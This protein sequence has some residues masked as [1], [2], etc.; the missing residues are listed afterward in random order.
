MTD[1]RL[2]RQTAERLIGSRAQLLKFQCLLGF[3]GYV[4][5][6]FEVVDQRQSATKFTSFGNIKTFGTRISGASGKA[7]EFEIVQTAVRPGGC[8]P[9]M[10][11]ALSTL[12]APVHYVGMLGN[13]EVHPVFSEFAKRT[14]TYP[15]AEPGLV[16]TFDFPDGKVKLSQISGVHDVSWENI[17]KRLGEEPFRK[18]WNSAHFIGMVNWT[19][20]PHLS[21]IWK[22][23]LSDFTP[24]KPL[25]R[26]LM[27]FD[28]ADATQRL[29]A[30]LLAA[31]KII[32]EF[33][34]HNDVILGLNEPE[35][36]HVAKVLRLKKTPQT[37][38]GLTALSAAIRE[39]LGLHTVVI[40]PIQYA[41]GADAQ[42]EATVNGPF[43]AKP[44]IS[45][46]AGD[47]FNAGFV[48]GRLLGLGLPHSLQLAV[49]SSGFYVR[50][51]TS[52]N[53]EQLVRFLQTL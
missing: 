8:G 34:A 7:A 20:L 35:S 30:D 14:K 5:Q 38:K 41:V 53:R 47:H 19:N 50:H 28:L 13:K 23:L 44:K 31:L 2:A 52:A 12:G 33:Q 25:P 43:T 48:I 51:A 29:D 1:S 9:V 6:L 22:R 10:A 46:G 4:D 26:R 49:A 11:F 18:L 17:K 24:A 32:G 16:Q 27:F 15:I 39:K 37:P 3:D 45:T 40:H 21:A 42:G 36:Q